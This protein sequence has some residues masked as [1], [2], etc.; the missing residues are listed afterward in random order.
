MFIIHAT[1]VLTGNLIHVGIDRQNR[2]SLV[3]LYLT[4][5]LN[6]WWLCF[7]TIDMSC[8]LINGI[9][10]LENDVINL[11]HSVTLAL[12][13]LVCWYCFLHDLYMFLWLSDY[14]TPIY[15]RN[16]LCATKRDNVTGDYKGAL[17][18]SPKVHVEL[19]Y[20]EIRIC[21]SDCRRG[22]SGP[23]L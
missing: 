6:Q 16:T 5:S 1:I 15:R 8:H 2:V 17:Q 21:H 9:T 13:H 14:A 10:S 4:S 12:D 19:A 11:T 22:I 7:L 18:V 20:F 23:S 3:C